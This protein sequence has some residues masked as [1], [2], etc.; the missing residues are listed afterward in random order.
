MV[1]QG[2]DPTSETNPSRPNSDIRARLKEQK[3][4]KWVVMIHRYRETNTCGKMLKYIKCELSLTLI[5]RVDVIQHISE[6]THKL[7][8]LRFWVKV[9]CQSRK[10][11]FR[12]LAFAH[13]P[14]ELTKI[15]LLSHFVLEKTMENIFVSQVTKQWKVFKWAGLPSL[16][17]QRAQ[18]FASWLTKQGFVTYATNTLVFII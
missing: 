18:Y 10:L 9:W 8:V 7:N 12:P 2:V 1:A 3:S 4:N 15:P 6:R 5:E 14:P 17:C 11:L 13:S 16:V